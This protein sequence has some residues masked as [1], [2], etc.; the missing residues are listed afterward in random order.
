MLTFADQNDMVNISIKPTRGDNVLDL[1]FTNDCD[2]TYDKTYVNNSL[3]DHNMVILK[4]EK[5][6]INDENKT[7]INPYMN[8]I[9][10]FE[11]EYDS[12]NWR[13]FDQYICEYDISTIDD[14]SAEEQISE[15]YRLFDDAVEMFL[16]RKKIYDHE[17]KVKKKFI[18]DNIIKLLRKKLKLSKRR[19]DSDDWR[20]NHKI[21]EQISDIDN[22]LSDEYRHQRMIEEKK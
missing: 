18:P 12:E 7:N 2:Y 19:L 3:S 13:K 14:M 22:V 5:S 20:K 17:N 16:E 1:F 10:E 15:M 21:M 9:Y 4:Y 6:V 8:K 11:I